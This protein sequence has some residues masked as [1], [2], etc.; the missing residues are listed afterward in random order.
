MTGNERIAIVMDSVAK[1]VTSPKH[2]VELVVQI[3]GDVY[4]EARASVVA[5]LNPP[6]RPT[7]TGRGVCR[8]GA[9]GEGF[10]KYELGGEG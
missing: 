6:A 10:V 2:G 8:C 5:S 3:V 9:C 4:D 7:Q 1:G